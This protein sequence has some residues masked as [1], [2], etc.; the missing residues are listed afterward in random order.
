MENYIIRVL[1]R[2]P[3]DQSRID[4]LVEVVREGAERPF[5]TAEELWTILLGEKPDLLA[6][7]PAR[8]GERAGKQKHAVPRK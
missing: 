8:S 6:G 5:R 7:R 4:G 1:R 3:E 2:H